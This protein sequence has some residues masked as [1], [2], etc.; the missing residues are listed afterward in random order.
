MSSS[1]DLIKAIRSGRLAAVIAALDAGAQ[2]E[3]HDGQGDPGLPM[4]IACFMG[5]PEIVRE[6]AIRG[7]KVNFPDNNDPT[8]PL[9]MALRGKKSEV[10]K[11]LIELGVN[12]PAGVQTGLTEQEL[13]VAKWKAQHFGAATDPTGKVVNAVEEIEMVRCYGTDTNVLEADVMRYARE[14]DHKK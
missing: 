10:V 11:V 7:A 14:L 8:S 5:F 2:V 13:T 6:L 3:M 1:V 9:S 12:L 4:A